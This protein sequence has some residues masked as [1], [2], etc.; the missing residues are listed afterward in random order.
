MIIDD[1]PI[2]VKSEVVNLNVRVIDRNNRPI[3]TLSQNDF[4]IF[5][6]NIV[7]PIEFFAKEEVPTNYSLVVDNSN[8]MRFQLEKVIEAGKIII[9]TNQPG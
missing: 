7:Q 3:N 4:Q 1:T 9:S 8:S 2:I 6:E 5:E